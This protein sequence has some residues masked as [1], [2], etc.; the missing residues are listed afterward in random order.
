MM[1]YDSLIKPEAESILQ[2]VT[3]NYLGSGD[4]NGTPMRII[5]AD[6]N[7][8]R[9]L[10]DGLV[11]RGLIVLN[12]GDR[13]ENPYVQALPPEDTTVQL[14]KLRAATDFTHICMYPTAAYLSTVL[15]QNKYRDRP[16][17]A[18]LA[19][20]EHLFTF[21][22]FDLRVLEQYRND[23]RYWYE[24]D[25]T[26]GRISVKGEFFESK[27]MRESD[28]VLLKQFGFGYDDDMERCVMVMLCDLSD[29][30]P[31]HQQ[32]WKL[33]EIPGSFKAH[34][35]YI[36][37]VFGRWAEKES[38]FAAFSEELKTINAMSALMGR[39][40]MFRKDFTGESRPRK[41]G[42]LLRP[43]I[44]EFNEFA[45]LLDK[46][47]SDNIDVN[48]FQDEVSPE[49]LERRDDG[50]QV[51]RP[52]GSLRMLDE[53]LALKVKSNDP[54]PIAEMIA[55]FKRIR[56]LRQNP[57]HSIDEDDF[58]QKYVKEQRQLMIDAYQAVRMLRLVL[59]NHPSARAYKVPDWLYRGD[60]WTY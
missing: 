47:I 30:S 33:K 45:L 25:D 9:G 5:D 6:D 17:T 7:T 27:R 2:T 14:R 57:A 43:T 13:H 8:K 60:I 24:T 10:A 51:V 58:D 11:T 54:G 16:Y 21:I 18:R 3:K 26:Q 53:W 34:P 22:P 56:R 55:T 32:Q 52:K 28:Q 48:F 46:M 38:I 1:L 31:E 44:A 15:D 39:P 40:P 37:S 49:F 19:L 29:L 20:G 42:F 12:F 41:F 50:A 4:F 23:P 59:S 35:N 36:D